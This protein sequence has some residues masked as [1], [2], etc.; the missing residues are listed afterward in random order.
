M[1]RKNGCV[2][3]VL[4]T[5]SLWL[6]NSNISPRHQDCFSSSSSEDWE[7]C[8]ESCQLSGTDHSISYNSSASHKPP[9]PALPLS[10]DEGPLSIIS[11][12]DLPR[13]TPGAQRGSTPLLLILPFI[14]RRGTFQPT[15]RLWYQSVAQSP[16]L[17]HTHAHTHG[18]CCELPTVPW[19]TR[20]PVIS[21]SYL[22]MR[23]RA[24]W[25]SL[26]I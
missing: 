22:R 7:L 16:M 11:S 25:A 18:L 4:L 23:T 8:W 15:V 24:F 19:M 26:Q 5:L 3:C 6:S 20:A 9:L 13:C 14:W 12:S 21:G 17:P 10:E 1:Q 2:N